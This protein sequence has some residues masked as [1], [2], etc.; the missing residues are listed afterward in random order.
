MGVLANI[1]GAHE[2][3]DGTCEHATRCRHDKA[4]RTIHGSSQIEPSGLQ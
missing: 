1:S 2:L 4:T 3:F